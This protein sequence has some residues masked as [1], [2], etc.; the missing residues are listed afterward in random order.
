MT[1]S[2]P[3]ETEVVPENELQLPHGS[4]MNITHLGYQ[5]QARYMGLEPKDFGGTILDQRWKTLHFERS[6]IGVPA[7]R[8]FEWYLSA[9]SLMNFEAAQTLRWW[10][11]ADCIAKDFGGRLCVETRLVSFKITASYESKALAVAEEHPDS[12]RKGSI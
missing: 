4:S 1:D 6:P 3:T 9:A 10:F 11:L 12:W 2:I 8:E 5:V 7:A